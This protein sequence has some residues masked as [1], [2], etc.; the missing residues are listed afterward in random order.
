LGDERQGSTM[1]PPFPLTFLSETFNFGEVIILVIG[2]EDNFLKCCF[3]D[4]AN[5]YELSGGNQ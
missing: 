5:L 1:A 2:G 3:S 4:S